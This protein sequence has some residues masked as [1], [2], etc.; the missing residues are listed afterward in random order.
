MKKFKRILILIFALLSTTLGCIGFSNVK[1]NS[2]DLVSSMIN[3]DSRIEVIGKDGK[4]LGHETDWLYHKFSMYHQFRTF[5][6]YYESINDSENAPVVFN[7]DPIKVL[8]NTSNNQNYFNVELIEGGFPSTYPN[9]AGSSECMCDETL[10][11]SL[12]LPH[13]FP[14]TYNFSSRKNSASSE[15]EITITGVYRYKESNSYLSN[16]DEFGNKP[17]FTM[18]SNHFEFKLYR[19]RFKAIIRIPSSSNKFAI[20]SIFSYFSERDSVVEYHLF[21]SYFDYIENEP[22]SKLLNIE[23]KNLEIQKY[24]NNFSK[25][26]IVCSLIFCGATFILVFT[27]KKQLLSAMFLLITAVLI[28]VCLFVLEYISPLTIAGR[29]LFLVNDIG[30][31]L[32][33]VYLLAFSSMIWMAYER[34]ERKQKKLTIDI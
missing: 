34:I 9:R 26:F 13:S 8:I 16:K 25:I 31:A 30:A 17:N 22:L 5:D 6:I 18:I 19:P 24:T 12:S 33:I 23:T 29:T 4:N 32:T 7:G 14:V 27:D 1:I 20:A 2:Y 11:Q 28:L 10:F 21:N 3:T 15:N